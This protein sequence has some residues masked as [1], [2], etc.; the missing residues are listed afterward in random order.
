MLKWTGGPGCRTAG[1]RLGGRSL[2]PQVAEPTSRR[3][4]KLRCPQVATRR[5]FPTP[6][7]SHILCVSHQLAGSGGPGRDGVEI[8][9]I[10]CEEDEDG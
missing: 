9:E 5:A 6:L 8:R 4:H 7:L 10:C 3:P 2:C 1:L